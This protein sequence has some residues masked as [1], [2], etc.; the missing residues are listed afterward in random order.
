MVGCS[1]G[2]MTLRNKAA[3]RQFLCLFKSDKPQLT[4]AGKN[5][6]KIMAGQ[7]YAESYEA[8]TPSSLQ[9]RREAA[10]VFQ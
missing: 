6:K 2:Q 4:R 1:D 10:P 5:R 7:I 8:K 9:A 3:T